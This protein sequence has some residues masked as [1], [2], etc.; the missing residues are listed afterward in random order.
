MIAA[1]TSGHGFGYWKAARRPA[2]GLL[3]AHS[4]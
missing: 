1:P 4:F 2:L 3:I